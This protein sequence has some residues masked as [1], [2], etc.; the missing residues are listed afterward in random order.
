MTAGR[1]S[2][3]LSMFQ[4]PER[5]RGDN[6]CQCITNSCFLVS[7]FPLPSSQGAFSV[8]GTPTRKGKSPCIGWNPVAS[9]WWR[10]TGHPLASTLIN[11]RVASRHIFP[12]CMFRFGE[13]CSASHVV[14]R[15][16]LYRS[17]WVKLAVA[18]GLC[19]AAGSEL[20]KI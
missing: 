3:R 1:S 14:L 8:C 16:A 10:G 13:C 17:P 5:I 4:C 6:M 15:L 20:A 9:D 11:R 7:A 12:P 19:C 18:G 2:K